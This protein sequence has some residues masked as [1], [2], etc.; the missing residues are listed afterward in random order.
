[1][2]HP[3]NLTVNLNDKNIMGARPKMETIR[4]TSDEINRYVWLVNNMD[5]DQ[6]INGNAELGIEPKGA[7]N[8]ENNLVNR[9][10]TLIQ[11]G[12]PVFGGDYTTAN[13][14]DRFYMMNTILRDYRKQAKNYMISN[15]P[16]MIDI[17]SDEKINL[18]INTDF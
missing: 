14:E 13:Y 10:N 3:R 18:E 1:M 12:D 6:N 17:I 16:R 8:P 9:L 4:M 2:Y 11:G 5:T 15:E 7:Y